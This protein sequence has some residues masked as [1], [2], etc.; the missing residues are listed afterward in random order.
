MKGRI[1]LRRLG[2]GG[3]TTTH[4]GAHAPVW[5][6]YRG[7]F[8]IGCEGKL[9]PQLL[10]SDRNIT[11]L[12]AETPQSPEGRPT[13]FMRTSSTPKTPA[14]ICRDST[15]ATATWWCC[16]TTPTGWVLMGRITP[17]TSTQAHR[18]H[19]CSQ[20]RGFSNPKPR[21]TLHKIR[22]MDTVCP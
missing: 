17:S 21:T 5:C 16:T 2:P 15:C 11:C 1:H 4:L 18:N 10:H 13:W 20:H 14:T 3:L 12:P 8:E 6:H 19:T 7:H 9:P 22:V